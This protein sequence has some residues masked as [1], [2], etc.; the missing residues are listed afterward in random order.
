MKRSCPGI[1]NQSGWWR[2]HQNAHAASVS[3]RGATKPS[4]IYRDM[5]KNGS[6]SEGSKAIVPF[7]S[8]SACLKKCMDALT[9]RFHSARRFEFLYGTNESCFYDVS[10]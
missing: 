7:A 5:A 4:R 1:S 3:V 9:P 6:V 8:L 10:S 2:M